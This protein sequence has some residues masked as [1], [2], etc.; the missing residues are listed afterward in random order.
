MST[1]EKLQEAA[2][3]A[4]E[5]ADQAKKR[6]LLAEQREKQKLKSEERKKDTRKKL[7]VGAWALTQLS[8][9]RL[10]EKMNKYLTREDDRALFDL[11]PA[12][13]E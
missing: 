3:K 1:I 12:A 9:E 10:K 7:L 8:E 11:P 6:L 4:K 13:E 2:Q 5:K